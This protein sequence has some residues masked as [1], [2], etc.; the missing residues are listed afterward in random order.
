M[1]EV[2][3]KISQSYGDLR[4]TQKFKRRMDFLIY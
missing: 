3:D 2:L 1:C 4:C